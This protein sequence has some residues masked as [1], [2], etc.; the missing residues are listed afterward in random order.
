[1]RPLFLSLLVLSLGL[2]AV[3][4]AGNRAPAPQASGSTVGSEP[5]AAKKEDK[6]AASGKGTGMNGDAA[7]YETFAKAWARDNKDPHKAANL[8][9]QAL[10]AYTM[11]QNEGLGMIAL[12]L[13]EDDVHEDKNVPGGFEPIAS[14]RDDLLQLLKKPDVMKGYC[15]GTIE[16]RYEDAK[17]PDCQAVFDTDYS[18]TRQGVGYPKEGRAKFFIANGGSSRP[19]PM[20]LIKQDD[21]T[22]KVHNWGG[23]LTGV[24]RVE[25]DE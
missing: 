15:G 18:S 14:H 4:C 13:S 21:G 10:A 8:F 6:A 2:P 1:M 25:E 16:G 12:T 9:L 11:D 20:E 22:W 17:I 7:N 23:L 24:A 5:I 19:R 3:A